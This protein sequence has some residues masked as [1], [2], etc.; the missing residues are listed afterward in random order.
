MN[1]QETESTPPPGEHGPPPAEES[2]PPLRRLTEVMAFE[3]CSSI[4]VGLLVTVFHGYFWLN[5]IVTL[6]VLAAVSVFVWRSRPDL[7]HNVL[8]GATTTLAWMARALACL[9]AGAAAMVLVLLAALGVRALRDAAQPCGQPLELR[10]LTAPEMLTPLRAA[11]SEFVADRTDGGCRRYTVT[12]VPEPGPVSLYDAFSR[13]WRRNDTGDDRQLLGPQPDIWIPATSAELAFVPHS[14]K[15]SAG[16]P[17]PGTGGGQA[18]SGQAGGGQAGPG[19]TGDPRFQQLSRSLGISPMVLALFPKA[20]ATVASPYS[21]PLKQNVGELLNQI[22]QAGVKLRGIARPVPDTSSAALEVTPALYDAQ[23][24]TDPS[25]DEKFASPPDLVAPDAVTL[26]CRF[27]AEAAQGK[28]P[29]E[30]AVAV[31]EQVLADYDAGRA[32]GDRCGPVDPSAAPNAGWRLHPYYAVGLPSMDYPLVQLT[33]RGQDTRARTDAIGD[34]R[35]WLAAHPLTE[36]GLRDGNGETPAQP[37]GD[38]AHYYLSRLQ[39]MLGERAMPPGVPLNGAPPVQTALNRLAAA[40]PKVSASLMLDISGSMDQAAGSGPA[41]R[42]SPTAGTAPVSGGTR[43]NRA[44]TF[45]QSF[46]EQLQ[47]SDRVGLQVFSSAADPRN[48]GTFGNVPAG[49][50]QSAQKDQVVNRLQAVTTAGGDRALRSVLSA[51]SLASGRQDLILV[52]D[53]AG[54]NPDFA[55]TVSWLSGPFNQANPNL[56]LTVVLTGPAGCG[57][58]HIKQLTSALGPGR[59]R[60]TA[61]TGAP[62]QEQA[63][64]FLSGLR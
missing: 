11:A 23:A 28:E 32:L 34:L 2:R 12:V 60:C 37:E 61:L 22:A 27:R 14:G 4:L 36:Q 59:G 31:P 17:A 64:Q 25:A 43:L 49:D 56:R 20:D 53:G 6:A 38:S 21:A 62:E 55:G 52:T 30:I 51:A 50:A 42:S 15:A 10:V 58:P 41:P 48:A 3:L 33:W 40:R 63:A 24:N 29:P 1:G 13:L 26:L 7:V 18:G 5:S 39:N 35:S 16:A 47:G 8:A 45:L 54:S 46:V 57:T 19:G 44:V 9:L